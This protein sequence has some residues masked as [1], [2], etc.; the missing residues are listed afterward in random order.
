MG[1]GLAERVKGKGE[2]GRGGEETYMMEIR[3]YNIEKRN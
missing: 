3:I 1:K 2:E